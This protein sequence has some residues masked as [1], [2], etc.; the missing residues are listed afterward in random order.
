MSAVAIHQNRVPGN[1]PLL[2]RSPVALAPHL[3][4]ASFNQRH[5]PLSSFVH[6]YTTLFIRACI[7]LTRITP[8]I[9]CPSDWTTVRG[10]DHPTKVATLL[11]ATQC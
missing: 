2:A 3:H 6:L 7:P 9:A 10:P 4:I 1:R 11:Y 8:S 5:T